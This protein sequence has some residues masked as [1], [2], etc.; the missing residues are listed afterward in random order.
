MI[1]DFEYCAYNYRGFDLAN[2]FLEW[3]FDYTNEKFP[4]FHH[5]KNQYPTKE[6][7]VIIGHVCAHLHIYV[8]HVPLPKAHTAQI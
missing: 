4:Y 5:R 3:T 6:Q 1:I 8:F 7:K 2:H